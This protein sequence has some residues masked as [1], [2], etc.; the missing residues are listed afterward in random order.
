MGDQVAFESAGVVEVEVLEALAGREP[1]G[2]DPSLAA[3]G[4]AGG[5]LPVQAGGEELLMGPG[6][7]PVKEVLDGVEILDEAFH[8]LFIGPDIDARAQAINTAKGPHR[9]TRT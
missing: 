1:G 5:D 2:A 7:C 9:P 3:V 8:R 6:L 4:L